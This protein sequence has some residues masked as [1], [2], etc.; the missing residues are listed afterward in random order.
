[1]SLEYHPKIGSLVVADYSKGFSVPEMVK[2]RL[3]VVISPAISARQGL[4]TIVPLS[5]TRSDREMP[6]HYLLNI[7]FSMPE[8]WSQQ[9]VWVKGDMVNAVGWH[10]LSMLRLGKD[11]HGKRVYQTKTIADSDL[12]QIR[13]CVLHGLGMSVLAK[14]VS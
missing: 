4:C 1:M 8:K 9:T 6:Y 5:T 2:R 10:R 12:R 7:P 3:A 11:R 14:H 13:Q